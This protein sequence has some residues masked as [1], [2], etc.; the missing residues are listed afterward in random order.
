MRCWWLWVALLGAPAMAAAQTPLIEP[1]VALSCLTPAKEQRGVPEYPFDAWKRRQAGRVQVELA[2]GGPDSTPEVRVLSHEGDD[3]FVE[4]VKAHVRQLRV[5]CLDEQTPHARLAFDFVFRPDERKAV[6]ADPTDPD[7][8]ASIRKAA[9]IRHVDGREA[10]AYPTAA[11]DEN[12]QGRVFLEMRFTGP[13]TPP[14]ATVFSATGRGPLHRAVANWAAGARMPCFD[15]P[16]PVTVSVTYV[17]VMS[18][19]GA[20]GFKPLTLPKFLGAVR[21]IR[22]QRLEFDFTRLDCPFDVRLTYLQPG[23]KNVVAQLDDNNPARQP[24]IEWLK[25]VQLD[26]PASSLEAVYADSLTLTVPCTKLNLNSQE[27]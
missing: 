24:F 16:A 21:D 3:S 22:R 5:P 17:Y 2:F 9:C 10:P 4:A 12:I 20:Y 23:R 26:L 6:A 7:R 15:G 1:S 27:Q 8:E 11:R 25:G 14:E 13:D 18:G 19:K